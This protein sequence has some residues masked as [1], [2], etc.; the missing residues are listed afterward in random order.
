MKPPKT[1]LLYR[2]QHA[3]ADSDVTSHVTELQL[4]HSFDL[5][6]TNELYNV[7]TGGRYS[8]VEY[9]AAHLWVMDERS[10]LA[11]WR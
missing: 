3:V 8:P 7:V 10:S 11:V 2:L 9:A 6:L 1:Y 4:H 5:T